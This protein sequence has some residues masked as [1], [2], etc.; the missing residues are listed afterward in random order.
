MTIRAMGFVGFHDSGKTTLVARL[1]NQLQVMGHRVGII[2][3]SGQEFDL[4]A[5]DT[6]KLAA[7]GCPVAGK[8]PG[9]TMLVLPR[10]F[11]VASL[12]P[13]LEADILLV[14]GGKSLTFLPRVVLPK[15]TQDFAKLD[16]G[17]AYGFWGDEMIN[18]HSRISSLE[19][20]ASLVLEKGFL[21]PALNCGECGRADCAGLARDI[22][23]GKAGQQDCQARS[24]QLQ[25]LVNG[26]PIGMNPFV[27]SIMTSTI[28]GMLSQLKGFAPGAI[29]IRVEGP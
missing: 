14:E 11:S 25:V 1:A 28:R 23:A 27:A 2:K 9:Q 24:A 26:A 3:S 4:G 20:L 17:L 18:G 15:G 13:L 10:E 12:M 8:A 5:T 7:T 29:E 21:L 6:G 16:S 19:E 22:V